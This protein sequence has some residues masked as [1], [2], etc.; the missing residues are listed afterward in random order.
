MFSPLLTAAPTV[1]T[2]AYAA[3]TLSVPAAVL[4]QDIDC[5]LAA[6]KFVAI[7]GIASAAFTALTASYAPLNVAIGGFV[8]GFVGNYITNKY[9]S[10]G[11]RLVS[12]IFWAALL[13]TPA[14]SIVVNGLG[15]FGARCVSYLA[16]SMSQVPK[17]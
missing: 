2:I 12:G 17:S 4:T 11:E 13:G 6:V 10:F 15:M 8:F 16:D 14:A 3:I 5:G 7:L 9:A 1:G